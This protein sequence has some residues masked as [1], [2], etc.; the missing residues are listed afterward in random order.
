MCAG[1]QFS[2]QEPK[3]KRIFNK[4]NKIY[5]NVQNV[6]YS[7][8]QPIVLKV[9]REIKHISHSEPGAGILAGLAWE[10]GLLTQ[11][12][13]REAVEEPTF[14]HTQSTSSG[15]ACTLRGCG[16]HP[17]QGEVKYPHMFLHGSNTA[18]GLTLPSCYYL[19]PLSSTL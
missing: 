5:T 4:V 1:H 13:H 7:N 6:F 15:I 2:I 17:S 18:T 19:P 8:E 9:D 11:G 3:I 14:C 16:L 12:L 10:L